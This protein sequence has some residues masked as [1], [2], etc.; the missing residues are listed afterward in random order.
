[1]MTD[2]SFLNI[3]MEIA[4]HATCSRLQ[5]GAVLVRDN[6][7]FATGYNGAPSG[8]PHC[9][10]E[11]SD[12]PCTTSVHAETNVL[13][14]AARIGVSTMNSY[15]FLTHAPCRACAGLIIN[16]GIVGVTYSEVYRD[17]RGITRL[18]D[19]K[20]SAMNVDPQDG[21]KGTWFPKRMPAYLATSVKP[22]KHD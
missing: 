14:S 22:V 6:R 19:A 21:L 16:A 18:I 17:M 2:Q 12:D 8:E 4:S 3:A 15:L 10:H 11:G 9:D 13:I 20:V 5:V 7:P 1:M